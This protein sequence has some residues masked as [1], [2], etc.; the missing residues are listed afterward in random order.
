MQKTTF[1]ARLCVLRF[2]ADVREMNLSQD[3][4]YIYLVYVIGKRGVYL[5]F[6]KKGSKR[7]YGFK[8][9]GFLTS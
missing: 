1:I 6:G 7:N 5:Q 2:N 4:L 9:I 8:E 3:G